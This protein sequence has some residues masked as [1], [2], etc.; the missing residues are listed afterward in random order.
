MCKSLHVME[1]DF[2]KVERKIQREELSPTD[3]AR[4]A[5]GA[6]AATTVTRLLRRKGGRRASVL[7][8]VGALGFT[9]DDV[10][11]KRGRAA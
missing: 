4:L 5:N 8:L 6:I 9:L 1:C 3:V 10:K 2:T 11:V 7:V